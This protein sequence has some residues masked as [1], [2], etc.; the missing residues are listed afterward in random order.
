MKRMRRITAVLVAMMMVFSLNVA[1]FAADYSGDPT[2]YTEGYHVMLNGEYVTFTDAVPVNKQG[3]I[4]VPF[5]AILEAL[6]AKVDWI[7]ETRT[8]TAKT[9]SEITF[10][11][12]HEMAGKELNFTIELIE[13]TAP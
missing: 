13:V 3:R 12:N 4:M 9:D 8:V 10:D 6:G 1:S 2:I 11:A 7:D 5:R